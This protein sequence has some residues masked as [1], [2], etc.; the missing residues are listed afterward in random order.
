MKNK[1]RINILPI[2]SELSGDH[3]F[4]IKIRRGDS[5]KT[6]FKNKTFLV[7]HRRNAVNHLRLLLFFIPCIF[8]QIDTAF[9][10]NAAGLMFK[11]WLFCHNKC[12]IITVH[13]LI[14]HGCIGRKCSTNLI[15]L[16]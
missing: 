8:G 5:H 12:S 6:T 11:K 1:S 16:I 15:S 4:M 13:R 10:T 3:F 2:T 14:R 9:K 7:D